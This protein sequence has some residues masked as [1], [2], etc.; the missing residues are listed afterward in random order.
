MIK[1]KVV[2]LEKLYNFVV[3]NFLIWFSLGH[4]NLPSVFFDTRQ[5]RSLSSVKEKHSAKA[6]LSSV[7][8]NTR[9]RIFQI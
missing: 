2:G 1:I 7:K 9:Q 6:S 3:K 4:Q 8:K 5:R